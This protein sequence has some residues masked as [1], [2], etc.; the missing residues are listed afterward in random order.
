MKDLPL[1]TSQ[2]A[3]ALNS[4]ENVLRGRR[5]LLSVLIWF[6]EHSAHYR[7]IQGVRQ[8]GGGPEEVYLHV[9][10]NVAEARAGIGRY[11]AFFNDERAHQKLGNQ[12][13]AA[14]YAR[15]ASKTAA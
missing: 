5:F 15:E 12:T 11:L 2:T 4:S 10:D 3:S 8:L 9:Y 7:A 13:P 14:F 1:F 6:I